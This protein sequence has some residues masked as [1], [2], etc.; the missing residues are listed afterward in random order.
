VRLL[1]ADLNAHDSW[2]LSGS[3]TGWGDPLVSLFDL[4]ILVSTPTPVR[5]NRLLK[6]EGDRY[7]SDALAPGGVMHEQHLAFIEWASRYDDG[8]ESVR[9]RRLHEKWLASVTAPVLR[10]DGQ[11][12]PETLVAC[13]LE[14]LAE[15][16]PSGGR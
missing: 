4:V 5:I 6:R 3:L 7:G 15:K 14:A 16:A 2:V 10:V 9:S 12:P 1:A 13:V 8:D 11:D